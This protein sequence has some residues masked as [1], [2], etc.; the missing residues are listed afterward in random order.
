M[1]LATDFRGL[2]SNTPHLTKGGNHGDQLWTIS[3]SGKPVT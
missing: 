1:I 3:P 2:G